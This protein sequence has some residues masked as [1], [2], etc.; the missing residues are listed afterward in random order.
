[1]VRDRATLQVGLLSINNALQV[2]LDQVVKAKLIDLKY[3]SIEF[4]SSLGYTK[5]H[6]VND[7]VEF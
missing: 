1:V 2:H 5:G 6:G 7:H 3:L 4:E